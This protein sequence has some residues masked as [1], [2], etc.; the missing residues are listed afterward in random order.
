MVLFA[1]PASEPE[2]WA[3]VDALGPDFGTLVV[4]ATVRPEAAGQLIIGGVPK[5]RLPLLVFLL[6]LTLGVGAA[7][8]IQLRRE[9]RF[10]RLRDDFVSGVSHELRT[11]LAQIQMFAEL[12]Q[13]DK[14][15][16]PAERERAVAVIHREARRLAHLVENILQFSRLRRA[17]AQGLPTE[18]LDMAVGFA[19]GIDAVTPLLED[20]G[21]QLELSTER[22]LVVRANRDSLTRIIV[23]L[24]DNAVK[25]G[26]VG[27]TVKVT[28]GRTDGAARLT[29]VDEG[30][31]IPIADRDSVWKPYRRL[32]RGVEAATPGTGIGLSLVQ[33][34][35]SLHGGRVWIEGDRGGGTR[36]VVELPLAGD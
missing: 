15:S 5:A 2:H 6:A 9:L 22:G 20:R 29:V 34:L 19:D 30:P 8:I 32:A 16:T 3:A 31:G 21:M 25:Y 12:Q 35:V 28:I 1:S 10:Q 36:V 26:P 17:T 27:Q 18:D 23:N 24:L 14:L 13:A 4:E 11:P 7:A 33:Q